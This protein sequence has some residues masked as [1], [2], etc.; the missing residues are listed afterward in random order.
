MD[1]GS[2]VVFCC[3]VIRAMHSVAPG[4]SCSHLATT[5][6]ELIWLLHGGNFGGVCACFS[7]RLPAFR[8]MYVGFGNRRS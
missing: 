6:Q 2:Y 1:F 8:V 5:I 3:T 4:P 7:T